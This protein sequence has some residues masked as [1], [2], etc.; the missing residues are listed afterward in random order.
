MKMLV[1]EKCGSTDFFEKNGFR[2][3]SYCRTKYALQQSDAEPRTS[4]IDLDGDVAR[5]LRKCRENPARAR[6]Y[7]NLVLDMD[8]GNTEA[9]RYL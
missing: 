3:C 8:P 4:D 1:C 6:R 2:I 5:L 9:L 7:A